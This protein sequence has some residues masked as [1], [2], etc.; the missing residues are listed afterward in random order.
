VRVE[1]LD[2]ETQMRHLAVSEPRGRSGVH[3]GSGPTRI[4]IVD[5]HQVVAEALAETLGAV[6]AFEVAG[7]AADL[8]GGLA[9]IAEVRPDV[10]I[11][12]VR[13]PDGDGAAGTADVLRAVPSAKVLVLSAETGLD[14]VARAIEG[15]AA[16]FLTKTTPLHELVEAVHRVDGGAVLYTAELLRDV[17]QHLRRAEQRVGQDLSARELEVLELLRTGTSTQ[18][19]ASTLHL[20]T[21]TVRNHVR[22]I[23]A[24]LGAHSKLEAVAVATR[25]GLF[26][27]HRP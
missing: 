5:D 13:L 27:A 20:S 19:M 3:E 1:R 11:L 10:V 21:H 23:S 16:G 12:D 25:E 15:G 22:N 6:E 14:V 26:D 18:D 24:K 9:L 17:A 2:V 4:V 8:A 7:T